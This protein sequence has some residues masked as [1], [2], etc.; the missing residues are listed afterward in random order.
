MWKPMALN[1]FNT[2]S[3]KGNILN[4]VCENSSVVQDRIK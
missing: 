2:M 1:D 4:R 3:A